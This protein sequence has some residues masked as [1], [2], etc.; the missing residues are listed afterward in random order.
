MSA[1]DGG[2]GKLSPATM[3]AD[4][5]GR[6]AVVEQ[7]VSELGDDLN[8]IGG[9]TRAIQKGVGELD[10]SVQELNVRML[11]M[12]QEVE[13]EEEDD[14]TLLVD[15]STLD[16]RGALREWDRLY[17]WLDTW[18]VPTY[19]ITVGDLRSCWTYHAA[20]REELSWLRVC[21]AQ[22]YRR[23]RSAGSAAGEWHTRWLPGAIERIKKHLQAAGCNSGRHRSEQ[24][25]P[26][27]FR[28]LNSYDLATQKTW[29]D[30]GRIEHVERLAG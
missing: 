21:W 1:L 3:L 22:T 13:D 25:L 29:M 23:P 20:V 24:N 14:E 18:L 19:E 15:W 28:K 10:R 8:D 6:V 5:I 26:D 7:K 9:A 2:P 16:R 11:A 12:S 27:E 4:A 30:G 17:L